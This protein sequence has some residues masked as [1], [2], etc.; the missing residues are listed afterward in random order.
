MGTKVVVRPLTLAAYEER[1]KSGLLRTQTKKVLSFEEWWGIF[2]HNLINSIPSGDAVEHTRVYGDLVVSVLERLVPQVERNKHI[3]SGLLTQLVEACGALSSSHKDVCEQFVAMSMQ[4]MEQC[5]EVS[6]ANV[7]VW[8]LAVNAIHDR[9]ATLRSHLEGV[10]KNMSGTKRRFGEI[11]EKNGA[12]SAFEKEVQQIIDNEY[13]EHHALINAVSK[14][15]TKRAC[16][17][18]VQTSLEN[19]HQM[20]NAQTDFS[21]EIR[22]LRSSLM[23][24]NPQ[25]CIRISRVISL[26][27]ELR[28]HT[29]WIHSHDMI[30]SAYR[31][32]IDVI[33]VFETYMT[34]LT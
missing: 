21:G 29:L 30:S 15:Q 20:P 18:I 32:T 11:I 13:D 1:G 4:H 22:T 28:R 3:K 34:D 10:M 25:E 8:S 2:A 26:M 19:I 23:T 16:Q 17:E 12:A 27:E 24:S 7:G 5:M 9:M 6:M 14:E 31:D 33:G